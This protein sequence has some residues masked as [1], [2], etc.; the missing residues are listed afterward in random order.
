M[1]KN[2]NNRVEFADRIKQFLVEELG[3]SAKELV[4]RLKTNHQFMA[5]VLRVPEEHKEV[6]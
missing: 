3:L 1:I 5:G 2:K 6:S 4:E